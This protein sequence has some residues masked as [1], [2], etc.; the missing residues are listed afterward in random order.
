MSRP[1]SRKREL[2]RRW[3][4]DPTLDLSAEDRAVLEEYL[5]RYPDDSTLT[6]FDR[7]RLARQFGLLAGR[8]PAE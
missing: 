1:E 8:L 6:P 4:A 3:L 2:A 5:E 7:R